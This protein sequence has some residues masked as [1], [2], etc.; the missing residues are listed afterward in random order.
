[1]NKIKTDVYS[2]IKLEVETLKKLGFKKANL[3]CRLLL[4]EILDKAHPLYSNQ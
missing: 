2:I 1:M 4:S 3:D